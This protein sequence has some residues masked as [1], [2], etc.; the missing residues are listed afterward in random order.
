[1]S[2]SASSSSFATPT[3]VHHRIPQF[4]LRLRDRADA[5]PLNAAGIALW[6]EY[7]HEAMRYGVD[8]D[9]T[10]EELAALI[11]GSTVAIPREEH[12]AGHEADFVRWGRMGGCSTLARY[13]RAWFKALAHYRWGKIT[14]G[15]LA[16][17]RTPAPAAFGVAA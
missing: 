6:L 1:M 8:P 15:E 9:A 14:A 16:G 10:R 13:G 17:A 4:L 2:A 7:E 3:E 11:E 12:R 5:A